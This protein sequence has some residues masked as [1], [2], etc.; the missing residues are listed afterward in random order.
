MHTGNYNIHSNSEMHYNGQNS[1]GPALQER[2]DMNYNIQRHIHSL[3]S[4]VVHYYL[5]S[6]NL[7]AT[8]QNYYIYCCIIKLCL[9]TCIQVAYCKPNTPPQAGVS[10]ISAICLLCFWCSNT[11][12]RMSAVCSGSQQSLMVMVPSL[13]SLQTQCQQ[14]LMCLEHLWN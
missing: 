13:T 11:F 14:I 9:H 1:S 8:L 5:T 10:P 2:G 4:W 6:W 7:W 12:V 3:E